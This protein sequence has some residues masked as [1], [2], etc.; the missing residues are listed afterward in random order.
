MNI[1]AE[2]TP[3]L[4]NCLEKVCRFW[5]ASVPRYI[6]N[7]RSAIKL[8]IQWTKMISWQ[9]AGSYNVQ[10]KTLSSFIHNSLANA[11]Q[12]NDFRIYLTD[13]I[14]NH[15]YRNSFFFLSVYHIFRAQDP[16]YSWRWDQRIYLRLFLAIQLNSHC[17]KIYHWQNPNFIRK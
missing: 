4:S 8:I 14:C 7:N 15:A 17:R 5:T 3:K 6:A 12:R 16:P 9:W 10:S 1:L 2:Q 13:I 11:Q